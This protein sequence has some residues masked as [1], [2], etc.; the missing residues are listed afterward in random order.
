MRL[1]GIVQ[2]KTMRKL[3]AYAILSAAVAAVI[4]LLVAP[5]IPSTL[6]PAD[7]AA[8]NLGR[9]DSGRPAATAAPPTY[10][11]MFFFSS[12][13]S[14]DTYRACATA[15]PRARRE[16]RTPVARPISCGSIRSVTPGKEILSM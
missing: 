4:T 3:C 16:P 14:T 13:P 15:P 12:L 8:R 9:D 6:N 10:F 2:K 7:R 1:K 11:G 5:G